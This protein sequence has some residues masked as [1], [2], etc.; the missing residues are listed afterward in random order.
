[1]ME[2]LSLG[3]HEYKRGNQ[4]LVVQ[5]VSIHMVIFL[6]WERQQ[7]YHMIYLHSFVF[8]RINILLS[9]LFFNELAAFLCL[10]EFFDG[11]LGL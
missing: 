7:N 4:A 6:V 9:N 1:M 5:L 10:Q 8:H 2:I 3:V 11:N